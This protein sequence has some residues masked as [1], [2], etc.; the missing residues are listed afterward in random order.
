[1]ER[2]SIIRELA[3]SGRWADL[4][5][6]EEGRSQFTTERSTGVPDD[7]N[8][9]KAH[10]SDDVAAIACF[11]LDRPGRAL[12][13]IDPGAERMQVMRLPPTPPPPAPVQHNPAAP[14]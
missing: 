6:L 13:A 5:D 10:R 9:R 7:E 3:E 2:V 12:P 11:D 4:R 8:E 1:L 14:Q